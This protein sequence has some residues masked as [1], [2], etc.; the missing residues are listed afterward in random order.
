MMNDKLLRAFIEAL[1]FD[2]EE[3]TKSTEVPDKS[4]P[5]VGATFISKK[6]V[7]YKVTKK[8]PEKP[9]VTFDALAVSTVLNRMFQ[10]E[11]Y[12][13]IIIAICKE[14]KHEKD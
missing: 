6:V 11:Q 10:P 8:N 3:L 1:G 2:I 4:R 14:T 13:K 9:K 12:N 7:D 5:E